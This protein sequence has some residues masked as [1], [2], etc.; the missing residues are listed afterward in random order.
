MFR[1]DSVGHTQPSVDCPRR[2]DLE[3][4]VFA[5]T[6]IVIELDIGITNCFQV[7]WRRDGPICL[8]CVRSHIE[9][10]FVPRR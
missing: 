10:D 5:N 7:T 1:E 2:V 8:R 3:E 9:V 6:I 4:Y